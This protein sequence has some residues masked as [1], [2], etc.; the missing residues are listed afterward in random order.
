MED[1]TEFERMSRIKER[2]ARMILNHTTSPSS[3][4]F[5]LSS[6]SSEAQLHQPLS[7]IPE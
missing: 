6:I 2:I 1:E 3:T 7:T 5:P 4:S